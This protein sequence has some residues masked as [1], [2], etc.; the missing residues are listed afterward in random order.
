ML[1]WWV[2][3]CGVHRRGRRKDNY[4][5]RLLVANLRG[6]GVTEIALQGFVYRMETMTNEIEVTQAD[7][8]MAASIR[9]ALIKACPDMPSYPAGVVEPFLAAH[10]TRNDAQVKEILAALEARGLEIRE[11][12]DGQPNSN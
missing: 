4:N 3:D 8:E 12:N 1:C 11:K 6:K 7:G 5:R 10:R 9:T 2:V